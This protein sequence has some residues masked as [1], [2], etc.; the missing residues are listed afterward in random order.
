ML[1]LQKMLRIIPL[2]GIILL[3][4]WGQKS[5]AQENTLEPIAQITGVSQL[6]DVSPEDWAYEALQGLIEQYDCLS[7]YPDNNFAGNRLVTRYE[8][9]AALNS[10]ISSIEAQLATRVDEALVFQTEFTILQR[11]REGFIVELALLRGDTDAV[12]ARVGEAEL[13][14]FSTTTKLRGL[15]VVNV[16]EAF[17]DRAILAEGETAFRQQTSTTDATR[18]VEDSNTTLSYLT[19]LTFLTSWTGRDNLTLQ[20]AAGNGDSPANSYASAG[21]FNTFG[22]PFTDQTSGLEANEVVIRELAYQFPVTEDVQVAI[23]TKVNWHRY[24]DYNNFTSAIDGASSFN[25]RNS[26]LLNAVERGTGAVVMWNINDQ[27]SLHSGYLEENNE[28]LSNPP[29]KRTSNPSEGF[30]SGTNTITTELTYSPLDNLNLRLLYNR[31]NFQV[32]DG[33]IGGATGKPVVGFAHYPGG[34]LASAR[35]NTFSFNFDWLPTS[36]LGLFGRYGYGNTILAGRDNGQRDL[37]VQSFQVGL[38]F[39]DLLKEGALGTI[40]YLVPFSVLEGRDTL[41]SGGGD[42]GV[43]YE[44]E[45]TYYYPLTDNI[46][47][48]PAFYWIGN[49]NNFSENPNLYVGNFRA[50]ISF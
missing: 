19:W 48:V 26:T 7:G 21:L 34:E 2:S 43:Q 17:S 36:G 42:G 40:S 18:L 1:I 10:C 3:L 41:L 4:V 9:A 12:Q 16:T 14:Q 49:A 38:A 24:F 39:P 33:Q 31:T 28:F 13:N 6:R 47:L 45:A 22:V 25:S 15:S 37:N 50:Q 20:L 27:L 44:L 5:F 23:G 30:F 8:F 32:I 46:A 35:A 29:F 11:L